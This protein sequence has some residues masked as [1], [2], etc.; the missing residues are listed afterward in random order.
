[1]ATELENDGTL[2]NALN[3]FLAANKLEGG[4]RKVRVKELWHQLLGPAVSNYTTGVDLRDDTLIVSLSSSVLRQEL[5]MGKSK[6]LAM[7]NE[8]LGSDPVKKLVLK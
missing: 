6:I 5:A 4:I 8:E 2:K 3:N 1:M 7:I